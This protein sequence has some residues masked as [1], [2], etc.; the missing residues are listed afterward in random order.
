M[1][2]ELIFSGFG[3]LLNIEVILFL[4]LGLAIGVLLGSIPGIS[5]MI[6]ISIMLVPSYYMEPLQ[7]IVFLSAIYTGSIYGGGLTAILLNIPGT[8]AAVPTCFDGYPLTQQGKYSVALGTG[9]GSSIIGVLISYTIILFLL[10]PIGS[11][12]LSLGPPEMLMV[13]I[14]AFSIIG[15]SKGSIRKTFI[16]GLIGLLLG[17]IGATPSGRPRGIMG[18]YA[19]FE[20]IDLVPALLG[21]LAVSELFFM[22][23]KE[24]IVK[25][26]DKKST[27]L[28]EIFEGIIYVF[29]NPVNAIRSALIGTGIGLL[30]AAGVTIASMTSYGQAQRASENPEKF[31]EGA[32]EGLM[33]AEVANNSS[34]GGSMATMLSF[35][36]PGS[37]TVAVLMAALMIHGL[38]PGPFLMRDH[39]DFAYAIIL[40]NIIGVFLLAII[41]VIFVY[42]FSNIV[43]IPTRILVPAIGIFSVLGAY[44]VRGLFIDVLVLLVFAFLGY[45]VRKYEYPIMGVVLGF[46]LGG[47]MDAEFVRTYTMYGNDP[48]ALFN[49][50]LFVVL[51]A[52]TL[53]S[54]IVPIITK[55]I[56][57]KGNVSS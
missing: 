39:L 3:M 15:A 56:K 27:N 29:K 53:L 42:Y 10:V 40:S 49:R 4:I 31:G 47:M 9:I 54:Y 45:L 28:K 18:E 41:A 19:L 13:V 48:L 57:G 14:F 44:S 33:A 26:G 32:Q 11:F 6:A 52:I 7:A 2:I 17:T 51:L 37:S 30:P 5:G 12:V 1:N 43:N 36:I 35:G 21:L 50:P 38:N 24:F 20:G 16:V 8:P 25:E 34:E 55:R 22:I 23:E 46:I